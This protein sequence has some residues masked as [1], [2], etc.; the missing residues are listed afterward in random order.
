MKGGKYSCCLIGAERN[1]TTNNVEVVYTLLSMIGGEPSKCYL[2]PWRA[3]R[4]NY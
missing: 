4:T 2:S 1:I 3:T